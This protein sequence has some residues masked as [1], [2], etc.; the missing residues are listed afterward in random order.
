MKVSRQKS[1][2]LFVLLCM[3]MKTFLYENSRWHC[4][5]MDLRESMR[6][7]AKVFCDGLLV[8]LAAKLFCLETFMV[9][10]SCLIDGARDW[11]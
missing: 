4:S 11:Q 8:Q 1:F 6:G 9:D 10:G 2:V 7:F 5:Y 3:S